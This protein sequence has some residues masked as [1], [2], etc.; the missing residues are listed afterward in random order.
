MAEWERIIAKGIIP[1]SFLNE[2][3]RND[4]LVDTAR[5]KIWLIQID[6]LFEVERICKKYDL[7]FF[8]I[9][10]NLIGAV[11]HHGFIPWDDDIDI[12]LKRSDYQ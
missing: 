2:E 7:T 3:V 1:T 6:M 11:R 10:G 12:A 4:F 8:T 5:K 9:G